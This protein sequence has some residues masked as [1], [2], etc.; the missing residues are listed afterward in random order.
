MAKFA[1]G[2]TGPKTEEY[3]IGLSVVLSGSKKLTDEQKEALLSTDAVRLV[4][5]DANDEGRVLAT[6]RLGAK[7]FSTGSVGFGLNVRGIRFSG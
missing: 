3:V 5:T 2:P 7:E 4:I 6:E 1:K